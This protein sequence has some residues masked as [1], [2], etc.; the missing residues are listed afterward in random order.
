MIIPIDTLLKAY[1]TF[2]K[3][4]NNIHPTGHTCRLFEQED[5]ATCEGCVAHQV[6]H[7]SCGFVIRHN[8]ELSYSLQLLY[9][10]YPELAI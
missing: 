5:G 8:P 3:N 4:N 7:D 1:P 10:K 2:I 9:D 6:E